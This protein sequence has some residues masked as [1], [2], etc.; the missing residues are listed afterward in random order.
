VVWRCSRS[1]RRGGVPAPPPCS[2]PDRGK[3]SV[4]LETF[5]TCCV[6]VTTSVLR[7]TVTARVSTL[8]THWVSPSDLSSSALSQATRDLVSGLVAVGLGDKAIMRLVQ[9]DL[10][11]WD[12]R[13]DFDRVASRD[14]LLSKQDIRNARRLN[15]KQLHADDTTSFDLMVRA[16]IAIEDSPVIFYKAPG[17]SARHGLE[18]DDWCLV[19]S[20]L[21][22]RDQLKENVATPHPLSSLYALCNPL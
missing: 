22:M 20:S 8:H 5:C 6:R 13:D 12:R 3:L 18:E 19:L 2:R 15:S 1:A 16:L 14:T 9:G 7:S 11:K 10:L 4:K 21:W 17:E